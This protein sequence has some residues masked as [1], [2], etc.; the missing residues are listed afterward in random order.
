M[1]AATLKVIVAREPLVAVWA[2]FRIFM[3]AATLKERVVEHFL[4]HREIAFPHLYGCGH[5]E[6]KHGRSPC[7]RRS[8]EFPHLY[9]CGHIE[10]T[11]YNLPQ[12][13]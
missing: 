5:I 1:D 2:N 13:G 4:S 8:I 9:G 6:G 3:D 11:S 12:T 7:R 10:G